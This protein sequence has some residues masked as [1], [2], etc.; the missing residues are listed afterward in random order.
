[1]KDIMCLKLEADN[2]EYFETNPLIKRSKLINE[3]IR[4]FLKEKKEK[5]E[6]KKHD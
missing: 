3:A 2:H 1:M 6:V 4:F 5:K